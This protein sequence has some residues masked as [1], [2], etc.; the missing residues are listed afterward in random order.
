MKLLDAL[1]EC[2]KVALLTVHILLL[3]VPLINSMLYISCSRVHHY[4]IEKQTDGTYMIP[5]GKK[6]I[7]PVELIMHHQSNQDGVITLLRTSCDRQQFQAPVAFRGM[8]YQ[9]LEQ[10]LIKKVESIKV[11]HK[12]YQ[13]LLL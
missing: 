8:T 1:C 6:F 2:S 10:E 5:A 9:D 12:Y 3:Q 13:H 7:G 4:S 11:H